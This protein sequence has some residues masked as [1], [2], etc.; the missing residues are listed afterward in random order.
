MTETEARDFIEKLV[1]ELPAVD[2]SPDWSVQVKATPDLLSPEQLQ[3]WGVAPRVRVDDDWVPLDDQNANWSV[4]VA[5]YHVARNSRTAIPR[6]HGI[7]V[8]I[9]D[10]LPDVATVYETL[11][12]GRE[13]WL[14]KRPFRTFRSLEDA[15]AANFDEPADV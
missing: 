2:T 5:W 11:R 3:A 12:A 15:S 9:L 7:A 14:S 4:T 8:A 1:Q 10:P 6:E 13:V